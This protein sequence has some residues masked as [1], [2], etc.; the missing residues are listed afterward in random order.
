[1]NVLKWQLPKEIRRTYHV[2]LQKQEI[3]KSLGLG[4]FKTLSGPAR[5]GSLS[6]SFNS[7]QHAR[8][9]FGLLS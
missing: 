2:K 8:N 1:M 3:R 7:T 9:S 6:L 4:Q 5:T